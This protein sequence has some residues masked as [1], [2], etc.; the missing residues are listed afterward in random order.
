[1]PSLH[2]HPHAPLATNTDANPVEL[3]VN[4]DLDPT[5]LRVAVG[6]PLLLGAGV[7][8]KPSHD[9]PPLRVKR[10]LEEGLSVE[11]L[12]LRLH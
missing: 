7:T 4:L 3:A 1:M 5:I 8:K 12:H 10:S 6:A 11:G 2:E 9:L